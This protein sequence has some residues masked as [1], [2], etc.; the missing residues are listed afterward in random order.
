MFL[1]KFVANQ[2]CVLENRHNRYCCQYPTLTVYIILALHPSSLLFTVIILFI[3]FVFYAVHKNISLMRRWL[4]SIMVGVHRP[5]PGYTYDLP[6]HIQSCVLKDK[7]YLNMEWKVG[8][9]FK[10]N[11]HNKPVFLFSFQYI[12]ERRRKRVFIFQGRET[13]G[14]C[15]STS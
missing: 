9:I 10:R 7:K 15:F 11:K 14:G 8:C 2:H 12:R 13:C 4:N 1:D 5:V 6:H 3:G